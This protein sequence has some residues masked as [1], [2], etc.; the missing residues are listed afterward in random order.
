MH[1]KTRR[2]VMASVEIRRSEESRE[3]LTGGGGE[4]SERGGGGVW[5]GA[6]GTT[7]QQL[8][9]YMVYLGKALP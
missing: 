6:E 9:R 2:L 4:E 3:Q 7:G 1:T 5:G 8:I